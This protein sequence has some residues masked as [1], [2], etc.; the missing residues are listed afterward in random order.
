MSIA[1]RPEAILIVAADEIYVRAAARHLRERGFPFV[2][3]ARSCAQGVAML[4]RVHPSVV[5][6]DTAPWTEGS[7]S[8]LVRRAE[9][10]GAAIVLVSEV[11]SAHAHHAGVTIMSRTELEGQSLGDH[12]CRLIAHAKL[13][14]RESA[15]AAAQVA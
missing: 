13:V 3:R 12:V 5:I 2:F 1:Q 14:S 7:L 9:Q 4:A 6:G 10:L 8:P 11:P 15:R